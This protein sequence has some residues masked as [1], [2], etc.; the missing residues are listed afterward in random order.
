[1]NSVCG[2]AERKFSSRVFRV[3]PRHALAG[4]AVAVVALAGAVS[5][6]TAGTGL[7]VFTVTG[8]YSGTNAVTNS[9]S[10]FLPGG[11]KTVQYSVNPGDTAEDI[12]N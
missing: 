2:N 7:P 5:P 8:T 3:A 9:A 6:A 4:M 10:V 1:M 11:I 12:A